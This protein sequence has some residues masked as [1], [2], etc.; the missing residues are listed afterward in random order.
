[1]PDLAKSVASLQAENAQLREA[2]DAAKRRADELEGDN[3][4]LRAAIDDALRP[5]PPPPRGAESPTRTLGEVDLGRTGRG[6]SSTSSVASSESAAGLQSLQRELEERRNAAV[7]EK[8]SMSSRAKATVG[9]HVGWVKGT[10]LAKKAA[11]T[12]KHSTPRSVATPDSSPAR[13]KRKDETPADLPPAGGGHG[14]AMS[15]SADGV[16]PA[17]AA[18]PTGA[19]AAGA[20]AG[21]A[22]GPAGEGSRSPPRSPRS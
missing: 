16:A 18:A 22:D 7:P 13:S 1:M 14:P 4:K 2:G 8:R 9:K 3:A 21:A 11:S 6:R 20:L 19:D 15:L 17:A 12:P 10:I 5:P